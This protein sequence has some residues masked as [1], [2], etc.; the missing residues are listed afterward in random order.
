MAV[1]CARLA[2]GKKA[3]DVM[4]LDIRKVAFITDYFV[5]AS[6]KNKK[7]LQAIADEVSQTLKARGLRRLGLE[8]YGEGAWILVDFGDVVVHLFHEEMR[9]YYELENL[10]SDGKKVRWQA[11]KAEPVEEGDT[12]EEA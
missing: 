7:Q 9:R 1:E 4:V 10:W 8:G 5:L 12:R 11:G 2:D 6:G 3:T